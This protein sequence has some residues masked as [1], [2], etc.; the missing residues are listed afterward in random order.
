MEHSN[1]VL[2]S[3]QDKASRKAPHDQ[4]SCLQN[5]TDFGI[6]NAS[7]RYPYE[8]LALLECFERR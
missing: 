7:S 2:S 3:V 5:Y 4:D 1:A 6:R 8:P